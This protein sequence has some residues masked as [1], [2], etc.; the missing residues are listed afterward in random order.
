MRAKKKHVEQ[1]KYYNVKCLSEIEDWNEE[2]KAKL[3]KY[4]AWDNDDFEHKTDQEL[5]TMG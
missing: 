3:F 5:W 1:Q 2:D 4:W